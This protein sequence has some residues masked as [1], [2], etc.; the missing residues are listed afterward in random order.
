MEDAKGI[1]LHLRAKNEID[2]SHW[3]TSDVTDAAYLFEAP[4]RETWNGRKWLFDSWQLPSGT[5]YAQ[6]VTRYAWESHLDAALPEGYSSH[7]PVRWLANELNLRPDRKIS[8]VWRDHNNE[9]IFQD[10]EGKEGGTIALLRMDQ[11]Q[12]VAGTENTFL[13]VLISERNVWPGGDNKNATWR[14]SEGVCWESGDGLKTVAW[15][16]DNGNGTSKEYVPKP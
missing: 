13:S 3:A 16:K 6:L 2:F 1:A 12:K 9:V 5:P 10:F 14:R 15:K 8:G 7:L 11:V 4:W